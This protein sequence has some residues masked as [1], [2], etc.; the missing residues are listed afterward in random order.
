MFLHLIKKVLHFR[1]GTLLKLLVKS[2]NLCLNFLTFK[3]LK[4]RWL[5]V[6]CGE[7]YLPP[8]YIT[9]QYRT[10]SI[11]DNWPTNICVEEVYLSRNKLITLGQLRSVYYLLLDTAYYGRVTV[12]YISIFLIQCSQTSVACHH[13]S[14]G[15]VGRA[16]Q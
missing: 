10:F 1:R 14:T 4:R 13:M 6:R 5:H 12:I 2:R 9:L 11:L 15:V 16:V 7:Y 3:W 8:K